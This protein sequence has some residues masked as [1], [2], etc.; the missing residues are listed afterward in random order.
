MVPICEMYSPG[1][2]ELL[3]GPIALRIRVQIHVEETLVVL[4]SP[5]L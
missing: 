1:S 3:I 2:T 4:P 5:Q